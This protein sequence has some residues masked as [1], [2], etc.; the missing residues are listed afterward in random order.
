MGRRVVV[1]DAAR[2]RAEGH[3]AALSLFEICKHVRDC[4]GGEGIG[5]EGGLAEWAATW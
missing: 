4:L 5:V 2:E 3:A 1:V